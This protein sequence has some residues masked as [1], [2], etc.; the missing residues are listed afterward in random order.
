MLRPIY[1]SKFYCDVF[2]VLFSLGS[3]VCIWN[4]LRW[5]TS[6]SFEE[7][8]IL[9]FSKIANDWCCQIFSSPRQRD[10]Y[11]EWKICLNE[12]HP[13]SKIK[14]FSLIGLICAASDTVLY[15]ITKSKEYFYCYNCG[16]ESNHHSKNCTVLEQQYLSVLE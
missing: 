15:C 14:W 5:R 8:S 2:H 16:E 3:A 7:W 10:R 1:I 13:I 9:Q 6:A 11:F 12:I 4:K